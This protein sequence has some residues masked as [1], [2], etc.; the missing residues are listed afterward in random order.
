MTKLTN[1]LIREDLAAN[2]VIG[3][4]HADQCQLIGNKRTIVSSLSGVVMINA[5]GNFIYGVGLTFASSDNHRSS[6]N[7]SVLQYIE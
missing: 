1:D 5:S 7:L 2:E 3:P 4:N 6:F